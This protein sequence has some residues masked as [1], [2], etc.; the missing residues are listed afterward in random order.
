MAGASL[1]AVSK[2]LRHTDPK[3]TARVYGHLAPE[4]L[5]GE[6]DKLAFG[7]S[8]AAPVLQDDELACQAEDEVDETLRAVA[9]FEWSGQWD[10]NSRPPAPKAKLLE[11]LD[12]LSTC[13]RCQERVASCTKVQ[14]VPDDVGTEGSAQT[15]GEGHL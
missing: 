3:I 2:I 13:K 10:S 11:L 5:L 9:G 6:A 8:F 12:H 14:A 1:I 4:Y 7:V 15:A